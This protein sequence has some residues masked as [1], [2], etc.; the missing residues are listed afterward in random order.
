[1]FPSFPCSNWGH[2][3]SPAPGNCWFCLIIFPQSGRDNI[4]YR[5]LNLLIKIR[6]LLF[7]PVCICVFL[8]V[9]DK[10]YQRTQVRYE[11][12]HCRDCC[13]A[14]DE[15]TCLGQKNWEVALTTFCWTQLFP[16]DFLT[17]CVSTWKQHRKP[18]N[19]QFVNSFKYFVLCLLSFMSNTS[20]VL[21]WEMIIFPLSN[22]Q[23]SEVLTL[24]VP[25]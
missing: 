8:S 15:Y 22:Y 1:M 12:I 20:L 4:S 6:V 13:S 21:L 18:N 7:L 23:D 5:T 19:L 11:R 3:R 10:G 25:K 9:D 14:S 24:E 2:K 17:S 16:V